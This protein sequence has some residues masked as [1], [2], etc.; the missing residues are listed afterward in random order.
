MQVAAMNVVERIPDMRTPRSAA[1]TILLFC[2]CGGPALAATCNLTIVGASVLDDASCAVTR[3]RGFTEVQDEGGAT[4]DI[5][6]SIM[7][8]RLPGSLSAERRH[9]ASTRF[10]QVVTSIDPDGKTCFFNYK[11]V[12]CIEE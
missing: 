11:A 8:A 5:R 2:A 12:L 4:I 7:S 1:L 3:G 6:R 9:Q 10:G